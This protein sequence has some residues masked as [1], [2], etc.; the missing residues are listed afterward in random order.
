[1]SETCDLS[2]L[3]GKNVAVADTAKNMIF[4]FK[5]PLKPK[6]KKNSRPIFVNKKTGKPFIGKDSSLRK[7]EEDCLLILTAQKN[8]LGLRDPITVPV[9]MK[10]IFEFIAECPA[11]GDNLETGTN[12]VIQSAKILKNDKQIKEAHWI[13]QEHTGRE[14]TLIEIEVPEKESPTDAMGFL[15]SIL[16]I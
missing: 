10:Y 5:I 11:D 4:R 16:K 3:A 14:Q 7:Y 9:R 6:Q 13:I 2:G 8:V 12:D 15:R 1:M